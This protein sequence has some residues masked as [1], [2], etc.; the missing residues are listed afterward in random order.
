MKCITILFLFYNILNCFGYDVIGTGCVDY[1]NETVCLKCGDAYDNNDLTC[2]TC[3]ESDPYIA[4]SKSNMFYGMDASEKCIAYDS[5][6]VL[7]PYYIPTSLEN[8]A[9]L[10][11]LKVTYFNGG[12]QFL[13]PQPCAIKTV[14]RTQ[15]VYGIY[16][17]VPVQ[18]SSDTTGKE[19]SYQ[20]T[21]QWNNVNKFQCNVVEL[22][23]NNPLKAVNECLSSGESMSG[24]MNC[25]WIGKMNKHY[26]VFIH[27]DRQYN[28]SYAGGILFSLK[29]PLF[30]PYIPF[31]ARAVEMLNQTHGDL[32][33]NVPMKVTGFYGYPVC[34]PNHYMKSVRFSAELIEGVSLLV[35]S[36]RTGMRYIQEYD[37]IKDPT[38]NEVK[39]RCIALHTSAIE[40]KLENQG[41]NQGLSLLIK[42]NSSKPADGVYKGMNYQKLYFAYLT[43][44]PEE[45]DY[46]KIAIVC[47]KDCNSNINAGVCSYRSGGCI[48]SRNK[49]GRACMDICYDNVTKEYNKAY[50]DPS[51]LCEYGVS[52]CSID[53][54]C[55]DEYQVI[56]HQCIKLTCLNNVESDS[57]LDCLK[58]TN[59]CQDNCICIEGYKPRNQENPSLGCILSTC[60]NGKLDEGEICD[61][62]Y[63]CLDTCQCAFN[64]MVSDGSLGCKNKAALS[65]WAII[66][67]CIGGVLLVITIIILSVTLTS[68]V[69]RT[70]NI[71]LSIYRQQQPIYYYDITRSTALNVI[72]STSALV[73]PHPVKDKYRIII[74][75][76]KLNFGTEDNLAEI[77]ETRFERF[78]VSNNSSKYMLLIFHTPNNPK[79][80]FHFMPQVHILR[81]HTIKVCT[82]FMTLHCTTKIFGL[83]IH[84]S[85]YFSNKRDVL[86]NISTLLKD[87][88]FAEWDETCKKEMDQNMKFVKYKF[89][90]SFTIETDAVNS[91]NLDMDEIQL[92]DEPIGEGAM[93]TVYVG[94]YRTIYV[95]VKQFKWENLS[96]EEMEELKQ[97]VVRECDLL[98][99]LRN[100]FVVNYVGSVTYI[101]QI[102][103]VTVFFELGSLNNYIHKGNKEGIILP[104]A[105]KNKILLDTAKGM[106][107]LHNNSILHLD[108]KP[109]NLLVNSLYA[110]SA[111]CVKITDFGTS[112]FIQRLNKDKGLGTPMYVA[113]EAYQDIYD[114][115]NDVFAYAITAWE[116]FYAEEPYKEFKSLFDIKNFVCE[117][118]RLPLDGPMPTEWKHLITSCWNQK[119][120]ERPIFSVIVNEVAKFENL[121]HPELD[122]GVNYEKI[123]ELTQSKKEKIND[124]LN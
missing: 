24:Q 47:P 42:Y 36:V 74:D 108:L 75:H 53:C 112:R 61:G 99:K 93:G 40:G 102:C 95:A 28:S 116:L 103:M 79:Y 81:S 58:G 46:L 83:K 80:V 107:F 86:N 90:G 30:E 44:E 119:P 70:K 27:S 1:L 120:S 51:L 115:P 67:I 25:N 96:N 100:P 62:G 84:V 110:D 92:L 14:S 117:G 3:R 101:P 55:D 57:S 114:C 60:G 121:S 38:T 35:R 18:N 50:G 45:D 76:S 43:T 73:D 48:C 23:D 89:H 31:T 34:A 33:L 87:R 109:D 71:D 98:S 122:V 52:H 88:T 104:F 21:I 106:N 91:I 54:E 2:K 22:D 10:N 69:I 17:D 113:P 7:S 15:Y 32:Y 85:C 8:I 26:K 97:D 94:K 56:N 64:N 29:Q 49:Y 65:T 78:V 12:M 19:Y 66:V 124:L 16:F 5:V 68:F 59:N 111:C 82:C 4:I 77:E 123:N 72:E 41:I 13:Y 118:K 9:K 63:N 105:L 6:T 37:L 20:A 11:T 39:E